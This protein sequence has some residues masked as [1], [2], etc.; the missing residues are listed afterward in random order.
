MDGVIDSEPPDLNTLVY[1]PLL[2]I[3][4]DTVPYFT[5]SKRSALSVSLLYSSTVL[6]RLID[7]KLAIDILS[8]LTEN[9]SRDSIGEEVSNTQMRF[10]KT[11]DSSRKSSL[12][13]VF[14]IIVLSF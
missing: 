8:M 3:A 1:D 7:V 10:L 13:L 5:G 2:L 11:I 9:T 4:A 14:I 12:V 6:V